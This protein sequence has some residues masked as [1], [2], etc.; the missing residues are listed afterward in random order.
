MILMLL[1]S[2]LFL[3]LFIGANIYAAYRLGNLLQLKRSKLIL[4]ILFA[5]GAVSIP[6]A[7]ILHRALW[8]D[9]TGFFYLIATTW[10]GIFLYILIFLAIFEMINLFK[11]L[12]RKAS[13]IA[14]IS[15]ALLVSV[16][17][18]WNACSFEVNQVEIPIKGLKKELRIIHISDVH[19]D[20]YRG[21]GYL[22]K[23][24]DATNGQKPDLVLMTGDIIDS[25]DGDSEE[26]FSP[27]KDI[28]VPVYFTTG[29]HESYGNLDR[30]LEI[31]SKSGVRILRN[32]VMETHG[33]QLIGLDYM[34]A[35]EDA[36]DLHPSIEKLTIKEV[37]PTIEISPDL[38][39][40]LMHHSP[41]GYKYVNERGIDLMLSGHT[42]GGQIFP[43]NWL[44]GLIFPYHKGLYNYN[45][46][47]IHVSQG[48][49]TFGP[50]M[51]VGTNNEI[52]L[53][54]LKSVPQF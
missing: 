49:G 44:T 47:Y 30:A 18:L 5:A 2:L 53:I 34:K 42:H 43:A 28:E 50:R 39:A 11:K 23:I 24:V 6:L 38:P 15:L 51:R 4:Y 3:A 37:L 36:L 10:M 17:G 1:I 14:V 48:A 8:N 25:I 54:I 52:T 41:V 16:Y 45:G 32:E 27:L 7:R 22:D 31:I 33:I 35:D 9:I 21:K 29:N 40:I 26:I 46:T 19:I 13:G 12:P 20:D